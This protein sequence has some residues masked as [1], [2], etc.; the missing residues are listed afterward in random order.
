MNA[1]QQHSLVPLW[2]W[3]VGLAALIWLCLPAYSVE[4]QWSPDPVQSDSGQ[5]VWLSG[6]VGPTEPMRAFTVYLTYDTLRMRLGA[7]PVPGG[8]I[9]GRAGLDFR[10]LD[11]V[12]TEPEWLEIGATIFSADFWTGPGEL[13][14]VPFYMRDCG[15]TVLHAP[16]GLAL[17]N[18]DDVFIGGDVRDAAVHIC[19]HIPQPVV[20]LT[21]T[22]LTA[23]SIMLRWPSIRF[24]TRDRALAGP[25]RYVIVRRAISGFA[26][27]ETLATVSDTAYTGG[28]SGAGYLYWIIAR[29][30]E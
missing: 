4:L 8:L 26:A 7:A 17:R 22:A 13:F 12:S 3:I 15:E 30:E 2:H 16:F 18:A 1:P 5:I 21:I 14:R 25:V 28:T 20:Q 27:A 9:A 24:D 6:V 23:D 19:P 11:H 29:S 10:Y